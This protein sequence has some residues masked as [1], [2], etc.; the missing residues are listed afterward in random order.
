MGASNSM[1]V[2]VDG[3]TLQVEGVDAATSLLDWL[4]QTGRTGTKEGC[5]EG[6][7]GACTVA[8]LDVD[9]A[10][11]PAWRSVCSCI[12]PL[13]AVA[14]REIVTVEGLAE[15]DAP[16]AAPRLEQLHPVQRAM[17]QNYGSQC[18]FC[19]PGFVVSMFEAFHRKDLGED[20]SPGALSDQLCGNLCRCTGYRPIREAMQD[21][22]G[23][24]GLP[25]RFD[26]ALEAP[27]KAPAEADYAAGGNRFL[28]PGSLGELL[29]ALADHPGAE[30]VAGATEI[31]VYRTKRFWEFPLLISTEGVAEL[32]R[33]TRSKGGWRIGGGATLTDLEDALGGHLFGLQ[34]MIRVFA[35]R[36]IR[37]RATV[38]GNLVT[39]SPIGDLAPVFLALDAQV[40]LSS[41]AGARVV[42]LD[43]FFTGYRKTVRR[44]DEVLTAVLIPHPATHAIFDSYKV[45]KRRELDIA[46]VSAGFRVD[47]V[48]GVVTAARLAYG[49][50][51]ATPAR[52]TDAEQALVG[53]PWPGGAAAALPALETAFSP[54][55]DVRSGAS[56]RQDLVSSLFAKF[57]AG[58]LS[59]AMEGDLDFRRDET[60]ELT[61]RK[62]A[63]SFSLHHESGIAHVT[64][65]AR[66]V[67]DEGA[68][69]GSLVIWPLCSPHARARI[70]AI[71]T[72]AA[73]AM[74]G[75]VDVITA[76]EIPG[77]NDVGALRRDEVALAAGE[78]S[79]H[80]Q[81]VA[82]VVASS[83]REARLAA[84][85]IAVEYEPLD[86]ALDVAAA[87]ASGDTFDPVHRI[88]RGE[89]EAAIAAA[90]H[91][92]SGRIDI[93]GQEHFYLESQAA[94]AAP[95]DAGDV[96]VSSST[97]HPTEV[98]EVVARVL[99]LPKHQVSVEAPRMGGGFGGKETQANGYA[100]LTAL[101][102]WRTGQPV[103]WMLDRDLD[104]V[105]TGKRHPFVATFEAG[106]DPDGR[107][108]GLQADLIADAGYAF[109]LSGSIRD[110]ALFHIDNAYHLPA[111]EVTGHTARTNRSS[112]TAYRGFGGP[113]GMVVVEEVFDRIAET[114]G[115]P[116]EQ[117]RER[118]LYA[119]ATD[120]TP[121]GQ[122]VGDPRI[123]RIWPQ[124]LRVSEFEA[125]RRSV[126]DFNA[127]RQASRRGLAITPMKFGISFTASMLNQ[128]GALVLIYKDGTV[129]VNH[130]GTEMGQ[131]LY[132]KMQ[133]VA[134]RELGLPASA[135]R[136]MKTR[137]DKVPNTSAT[138]ASSGA[139]LNGA[140]VAA[141]CETLRGRM[142]P[143]AASQL[144]IPVDEVAFSGGRVGNDSASLTF[145]EL[146][147]H[148]W[149]N[150]VSLSSTGFYATPGLTY[151]RDAGRG[152][153]F[154][155]FTWGAAV[156]EV[157]VDGHT[158][159]KRV[160]RVD[161]LQDV[162]DSLNPSVDRG[163]IEGAF[164]Q[165]L[166]WLTSEE[167]KW[168]DDGRLL[169]HSAS[170]YA[171]PAIGDA[172][173]DLRVSLLDDARQDGVVHGSKAVGEPPFM[174]ALSVR[175]ALKDAIAA[176]GGEGPVDLAC[177][178]THEAIRAAIVA[179]K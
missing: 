98:Q 7:C 79:Y 86:P 133:G 5:A 136:V 143:W 134:M 110:R 82:L 80:S 145:A 120:T 50:V 41:V 164:V 99:G 149:F 127:R 37:N 179:R 117:V 153:P 81:M 151:D 78:V 161:I 158:G 160:L 71:D 85:A 46:I 94:W 52:A 56:F 122:A 61:S 30:L 19:T 113:Q 53:Q 170:T 147:A 35:S 27:A 51:A 65:R 176:F 137:T 100:A 123:Q 156:S 107:L 116:A 45:S 1:Q 91:R 178:A 28:R 146:A 142:A 93:G 169:S 42:P 121:Y 83:Y 171:I 105:L 16:G 17:V 130:G 140:A 14:G 88:R 74:P 148:C 114:L 66:Y 67:D 106:F 135:V 29:R 49:G 177:P 172:P 34:K 72:T 95:G 2:V 125:R 68:R 9:H 108:L 152:H 84:D 167:L 4:R 96:F 162:G 62:A 132:T 12:T 22:L 3:Q 168:N 33:V 36:Q 128:A 126:D 77:V 47:V 89:P 111:I 155:Y 64:G 87:G 39:A 138:A 150:Q 26:R 32:R 44:P 8:L 25:T 90:P 54:L 97:Q 57:A 24:R 115:L 104:M 124:L 159:M 38:A 103:R 76:A 141:A 55:D 154:H 60:F 157:E 63:E 173:A 69:R 119:H 118:N 15:A 109:D 31:G 20:V 43:A 163:Q 59:D 165:G 18:G 75:V 102:A 144:G 175:A 21:A 11:E 166:G 131:G 58:D 73:R 112:F 48:D 10:G 101:A 70:R 40:E 139:D 13:P 92:L 23:E 129:Q 174:L 6:D